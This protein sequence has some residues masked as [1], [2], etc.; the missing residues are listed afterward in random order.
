ML[1]NSFN[2]KK[3]WEGC[4]LATIAHAVMVEEYPELT[5]ELSWD[6]INYNVQ[7]SCGCRGTISFHEKYLVA[8]FQDINNRKMI[9]ECIKNGALNILNINNEKIEYLAKEEAL[10]YVLD[11]I[12][13]KTMPLITA[14]F[15]GIDNDIFSS[16]E[17]E[18][19]EENGAYII[20]NHLLGFEEHLE[21]L[22][23]YYDISN[24]LVRLIE[25][26]YARK[27]HSP[28]K[29]LRLLEQEK[30]LLLEVYGSEI[31]ECKETFHEINL[32]C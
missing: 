18:I 21:A 8:A 10:Q 32:V 31:T 28:N 3:L 14:G 22:S 23:V 6:G 12:N 19:V 24:R 26:I 1:I 11:D 15:W 7:D 20:S 27:I 4:I 5:N 30:D 2:R 16:S 9:D 17:Y 13:G 25:S 29:T